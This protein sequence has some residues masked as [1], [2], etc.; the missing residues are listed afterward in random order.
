MTLFPNKVLFRGSGK[1]MDSEGEGEL[2]GNPNS[3]VLETSYRWKLLG[4]TQDLLNQ[5]LQG[6]APLSYFNKASR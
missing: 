3:L 2:V 6:R 5:K 1:G 4:P